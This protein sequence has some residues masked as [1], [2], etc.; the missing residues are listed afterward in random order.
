MSCQATST[1][2]SY[3][4]SHDEAATVRLY[5][6]PQ[7]E[8]TPPWSLN[9]RVRLESSSTLRSDGPLFRL[10]GND[11]WAMQ[12]G[13]AANGTPFSKQILDLLARYPVRRL[14]VRIGD[15]ASSTS[16]GLDYVSEEERG[17]SGTSIVASFVQPSAERLDHT[18]STQLKEQYQDEYASLL[19]YLL[20]RN[21]FPPCG[22]PL[23]SLR[24]RKH[25][26]STIV[27][28]PPPGNSERVVNVESFLAADA[29][30]FC[31]HGLHAFLLS[32]EEGWGAAADNGACHSSG[33]WGLFNS[34]FASSSGKALSELLLGS[35]LDAAPRGS[36]GG[37]YEELHLGGFA[38]GLGDG[39]EC[40][41]KATRGASYRVAL[42]AI[43]TQA[44]GK[45]LNLSLGDLLLGRHA[46]G[47]ALT[48]K[49]EGHKAWHPV[50]AV[51]FESN[52]DVPYPTNYAAA[53]FEEG[54]NAIGT[55]FRGIPEGG[56]LDLAAPWA[57]L[58]YRAS[59]TFAVSPQQFGI[60]RTVQRPM[61]VSNS[62]S[63][64]TVLRHGHVEGPDAIEVQSLDVIPGTL[65]KPR[66]RTLRMVLYDGG[67]AG[68]GSFTPPVSAVGEPFACNASVQRCKR[69][70]L[71]E[72]AGHGLT[73]HSDGTVLLER[74]VRLPP[75]SS[76]WMIVDFDE[77]YLPF[78]K[79]PADAN[80]GVDAFPS[81]AT[82]TPCSRTATL[83][84]SSVLLLPPVPDMSMP[85]NVI[86]LSCTLWAFV[87]GS[88][89]NI[90]VRRGTESVKREL[91]GEK[92]KRPLDR[93]KDKAE[94]EGQA[95]ERQAATAE[96][97]P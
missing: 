15:A 56:Y 77:A 75:D 19:R 78:Q 85:F 5:P 63:L 8:G 40:T 1:D 43:S 57:K 97:W 48:S 54:V 18:G 42:P 74:T 39:G 88:L 20:D 17:P 49:G 14:L 76:L 62:G 87:L 52:I 26:H 21:L 94:G 70:S 83:Y 44:G 16:S 79:F 96:G 55:E 22:A 95:V 6:S 50:P 90:L 45:T 72:L 41:V 86:S 12:E 68:E 35:S 64:V 65:V 37:K 60:A 32:K 13:A 69:V 59:E 28:A 31:T 10:D 24:V 89:L 11:A 61:G 82:F 93:L 84:S 73:L 2:N 25:G 47:H 71:S 66:M 29:A 27:H 46:L 53:M 9:S 81:R 51:G 3:S 34:L 80:R 36:D 92:E 91:T 67:G 38:D 33:N 4:Y 7:S 23:D 30:M 58:L